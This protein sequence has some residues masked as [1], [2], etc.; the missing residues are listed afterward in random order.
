[1]T[2]QLLEDPESSAEAV[3]GIGIEAVIEGIGARHQLGEQGPDF[4][5]E[6]SRKRLFAK[7]I[8]ENLHPG[9]E[10]RGPAAFEA[11]AARHAETEPSRDTADADK[12]IKSGGPTKPPEA[13]KPVES[14]KGGKAAK[15]AEKAA[16]KAAKGEKEEKKEPLSAPTFAGLKLRGI[17]PAFISGRIA[18][19]AVDPRHSATYYLA[20]ASGGDILSFALPRQ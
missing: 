4:E 9:P 5:L 6:L 20:V 14:G 3:A 17:G 10:R 19:F 18:D 11:A 7:G 1:M 15:A 13:V 12:V 16:E 8:A 2:T